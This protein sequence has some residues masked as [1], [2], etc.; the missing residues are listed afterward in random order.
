MKRNG[1]ESFSLTKFALPSSWLN[2]SSPKNL[3]TGSSLEK[4]NSKVLDFTFLKSVT[5]FLSSLSSE[6]I[7]LIG[8]IFD[9]ALKRCPAKIS[10][11]SPFL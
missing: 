10:V 9:K 5:S 8:A 3:F 1:A 11:D 7:T 6:V 2:T 4:G